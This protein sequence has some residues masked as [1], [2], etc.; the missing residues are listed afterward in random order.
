MGRGIRVFSISLIHM[1]REKKIG[2][3]NNYNFDNCRKMYATVLREIT[4]VNL[5]KITIGENI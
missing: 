1:A 4:I 5:R 3:L 2:W